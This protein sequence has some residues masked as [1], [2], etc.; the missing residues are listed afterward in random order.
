MRMR[1]LRK[2]GQRLF[3]DLVIEKLRSPSLRGLLQFGFDVKYST[4]KN[5]Y[6]EDRLMPRDLV[7]DFCEVAG[8]DFDSLEVEEVEENWG[9]VLGGKTGKRKS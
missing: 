5:Y 8:I 1:F 6:N 4:L 3:L 9:K 7:L 2:G